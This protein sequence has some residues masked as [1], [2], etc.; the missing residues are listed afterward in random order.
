MHISR[1]VEVIVG[2]FVAIGL[3]ALFFLSMQVSNLS[4][5]SSDAGYQI[6]ARFENIGSLKVRSPVTVAG[7]KVG[8][9]SGIEFDGETFEA[10][11]TMN[12]EGKFDQFPLDSSASILTAGLLGEQY[13]GLEPG[14]DDELLVDQS[15][16]E[17][18]QSALLLEK[19][20]GQFLFSQNQDE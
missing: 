5:L 20:I 12:I 6:T 15:E 17:I 3:I 14:G 16:L 7:V 10:L 11:V 9:V 2:F 1:T 19:I 8:R 4:S 18:T 13:I